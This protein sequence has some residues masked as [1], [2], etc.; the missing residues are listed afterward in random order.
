MEFFTGAEGTFLWCQKGRCHRLL[1]G[2]DFH[3]DPGPS[4]SVD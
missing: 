2:A 1:L 3:D 4:A